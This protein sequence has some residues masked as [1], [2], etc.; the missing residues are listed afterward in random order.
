MRVLS[1]TRVLVPLLLVALARPLLAADCPPA[2]SDR[3]ALDALKASKFELSDDAQR[4]KLALALLPCLSSSDASLRDGIAF[5]AYYSWMRA[6]QLDV[7]TRTELLARLSGMIE[8]TPPDAL[9][10]R[11]PFAALVL[12]EVARTDRIDA[13]L[14]PAQRAALVDSAAR[15]VISVRDS[16]GFDSK[17]GWRHGVAHGAD[18]LTQLVFNSAVDR[19]GVDRLLGAVA[20]PVAPAGEHSYIDGESERLARP[21]LF[22]AQRGLYT[23][24]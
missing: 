17:E 12:S 24:D 18:L 8:A 3:A 7:R 19:Q 21:V 16:R 15:Y 2:G 13:W 1:F 20:A 4:Q 6:N 22:A 23:S 11:Q 10:F 9:G 14:T 5:E